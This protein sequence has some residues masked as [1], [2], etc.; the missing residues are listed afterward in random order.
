MARSGVRVSLFILVALALVLVS[1]GKPNDENKIS[2]SQ[3]V[4]QAWK[5]ALKL[6]ADDAYFCKIVEKSNNEWRKEIEKKLKKAVSKV[7]SLVVN[8]VKVFLIS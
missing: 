3:R 1:A 6:A 4:L 2:E 8:E 7:K 5:I